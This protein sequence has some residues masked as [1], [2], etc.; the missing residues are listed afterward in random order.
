[1]LLPISVNLRCL[2]FVHEVFQNCSAVPYSHGEMCC[3]LYQRIC[4][5]TMRCPFKFDVLYKYW[6]SYWMNPMCL[7]YSLY[8]WRKS[9]QVFPRDVYRLRDSFKS[10]FPFIQHLLFWVVSNSSF[11]PWK[12][13]S[14]RIN[15]LFI[16]DFLS[17][18]L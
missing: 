16:A 5:L 8:S 3:C 2:D 15:F 18:S 11:V 14:L 7:L 17:S 10:F 12:H 9:E 6:K 1:M 4:A 13:I